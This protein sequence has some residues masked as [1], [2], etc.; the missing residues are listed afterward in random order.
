MS[1]LAKC[2]QKSS[3]S[4]NPPRSMHAWVRTELFKVLLSLS[5]AALGQRDSNRGRMN[6]GCTA[7]QVCLTNQ[8]KD[9][10]FSQI[11]YHVDKEIL[12]VWKNKLQVF[13]VDAVA[14]VSIKIALKTMHVVCRY[15]N[16][17]TYEHK[18][19]V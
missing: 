7:C 5:F 11:S 8:L 17:I 3:Y 19:I 12:N 16:N 14:E 6:F 13:A 15:I 2:G 1:L 9:L 18:H 4:Y 10:Y